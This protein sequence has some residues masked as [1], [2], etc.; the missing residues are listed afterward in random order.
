MARFVANSACKSQLS[1]EVIHRVGVKLSSP[2]RRPP[3]VSFIRVTLGL[4]LAVANGQPTADTP[5]AIQLVVPWICRDRLGSPSDLPVVRYLRGVLG[6]TNKD[7]RGTISVFGAAQ[8]LLGSHPDAA[9]V[10]VA[11]DALQLA[12]RRLP[13]KIRAGAYLIRCKEHHVT[14]RGR[15]Y[16]R[17]LNSTCCRM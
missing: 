8:G 15:N 13:P 12:C 16:V 2:R 3:A 6:R 1:I 9:D 11:I 10:F 4:P 7:S 14:V 5:H 17:D